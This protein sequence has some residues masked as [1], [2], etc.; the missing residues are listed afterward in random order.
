MPA[1]FESVGH[2]AAA[3]NRDH[4]FRSAQYYG[5]NSM[6]QDALCGIRSGSLHCSN[7]GLGS[8]SDGW[9]PDR[10][11]KACSAG[12]ACTADSIVK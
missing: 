7:G 11:L 12:K 3:F 9:S 2:H 4:V 8:R 1:R 10:R 6:L 5:H